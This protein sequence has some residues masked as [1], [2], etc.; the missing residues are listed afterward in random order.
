MEDKL[1]SNKEYD[2]IEI[3]KYGKKKIK[4]NKRIF[5]NRFLGTIFMMIIST[6]LIKKEELLFLNKY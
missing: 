3:S 5:S 6:S 1:V 2:E 4:P